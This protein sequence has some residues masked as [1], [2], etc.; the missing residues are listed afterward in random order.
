MTV[1]HN[2]DMGDRSNVQYSGG[3][4]LAYNK[5]QRTPL[6]EYIDYG[7]GVFR[8]EVWE[9]YAIEHPFDLADVYQKLL[10]GGHLA[11]Y[12]VPERF[13]EIGSLSGMKELEEHLKK[14]EKS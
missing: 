8:A 11:G 3:R 10:T 7:L 13:F 2:R 9:P 6:M 5:Q 12:E 1:F 14:P 4:I